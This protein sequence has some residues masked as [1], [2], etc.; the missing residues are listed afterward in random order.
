MYLKEGDFLVTTYPLDGKNEVYRIEE[1]AMSD[2][3][4]LI[5]PP[6]KSQVEVSKKMIPIIVEEDQQYVKVAS[7]FFRKGIKGETITTAI[8]GEY[9][10][11]QTI[12]NDDSYVLC[13]PTSL[14]MYVLGGEEFHSSYD[15]RSAVK[16]E[17]NHL[18]YENLR[19]R[20]FQEVFSK[21]KV[22][23]HKVNK[24]DME[25]F[26]SKKKACFIAPVRFYG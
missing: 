3:Y 1:S 23:A 4:N 9:E 13:G 15:S 5:R 12:D 18:P 24:E 22:L 20:G 17:H 7:S 21:R 26:Q 10:T 6:V 16:I 8:F 19:Q 11:E 25:W 14:E 2:T